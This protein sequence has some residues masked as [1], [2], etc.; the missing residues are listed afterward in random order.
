[1]FYTILKDVL[2][3]F[4]NLSVVLSAYISVHID[5]PCY[6]TIKSY[7]LSEI[8]IQSCKITSSMIKK[9]TTTNTVDKLRVSLLIA[10]VE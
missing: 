4:F 2:N 8:N 10:C 5:I 7:L 1:M 9:K 3:K 6:M